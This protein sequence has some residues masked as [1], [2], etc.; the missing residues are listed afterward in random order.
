MTRLLKRLIEK[1]QKDK[2]V[3]KHFPAPNDV[4]R[5]KSLYNPNSPNRPSRKPGQHLKSILLDDPSENI[6]TNSNIYDRHKRLPPRV[7][8]PNKAQV[9]AGDLDGPREMTEQ[10]RQWWTNPYLRMASSSVRICTYTDQLLP[11]DLLI[12]LASLRLPTSS[13][14]ASSNAAL[15][16]DG[17]QHPKFTV[18]RSGRASYVLCSRAAVDGMISGKKYRRY[19]REPINVG[20][21]LADQIGH[22][23]RLRVLQEIDLLADQLRAGLSGP[24]TTLIR[25]LSC[26]EWE[27][28]NSTSVIPLKN[29]VAILNLPPVEETPITGERVQPSMSAS[30]P[31]TE[32]RVT[33][34]DETPLPPLSTLISVSSDFRSSP[35][36]KALLPS[37]LLPT[38][39]VPLYNGLTAFPY[40]SQR[41]A[42][43]DLLLEL[44][45]LEHGRTNRWMPRRSITDSD[46]LIN[47]GDSHAFLLCA[48]SQNVKR[49]DMAAV[50]IALWRLRMFEGGGWIDSENIWSLGT[51]RDMQR[52]L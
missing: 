50:A 47:P 18:P 2:D 27:S 1:V 19:I 12:R 35:S 22:L 15:V 41:A 39:R 46:R 3:G 42:L 24:T 33:G 17:I 7:N 14:S 26:E 43:Y 52:L 10:E 49:G 48:D 6:I 31:L 25:K 37:Q 45:T 36:G 28:V 32:E 38:A 30:P 29:A 44:L 8:L 51:N 16:P 9:R 4:K 21:R 40:A 23:L 13:P 5:R 34:T 20:S 11:S